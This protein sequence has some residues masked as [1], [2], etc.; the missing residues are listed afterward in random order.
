[1]KETGGEKLEECCEEQGQL[2]EASKGGLGSEWAVVPI[3]M[4][5]RI[6]KN[7]KHPQL[8]YIFLAIF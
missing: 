3:M 1:V 2:A 6:S 5:Y 8:M 7:V 4:M